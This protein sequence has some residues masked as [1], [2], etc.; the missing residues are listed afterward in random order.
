MICY[1]HRIKYHNRLLQ[2]R[3]SKFNIIPDRFFC[4][5][6]FLDLRITF[7]MKHKL[8]LSENLLYFLAILGALFTVFSLTVDFSSLGLPRSSDKVMIY[9]GL[10]CSFVTALVLIANVFKNNI[11]SKYKWTLGFLVFGG[12]L[13]LFYL[14]FRDQYKIE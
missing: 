14:R 9:I 3:I 11:E 7:F 10:L 1:H 13:G 6:F 5:E 8:L 12:I 2:N 4:Q